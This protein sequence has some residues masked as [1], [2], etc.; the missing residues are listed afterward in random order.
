MAS[1][2]RASARALALR[3]SRASS[4]SSASAPSRGLRDAVIVAFARTP[5]G[6]IGGSLA[7]VT[8]PQLGSVAIRGALARAGVSAEEVQEVIFGNV[9]SAGVGQAP[10]RQA[11][12]G[13]GIPD[14]AVCTTINKV[15]AS[16]MKAVMCAWEGHRWEGIALRASV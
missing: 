7:S 8:A 1:L 4:S 2:S 12:R 16:G 10:A 6:T 5:I 3:A 14:S 15:C 11:A 9:V 13:A